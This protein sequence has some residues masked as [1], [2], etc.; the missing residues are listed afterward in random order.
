VHGDALAGAW[1]ALLDSLDRWLVLT[2]ADDAWE[3][4]YRDLRARADALTDQLAAMKVQSIMG[5]KTPLVRISG[6]MYRVGDTVSEDFTITSIEDRTVTL[7]ADGQ[8]FTLT[9]DLL[10]TGSKTGPARIGKGS[11]SGKK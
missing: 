4:A 2:T 6:E 8:K 5:G 1:A 3:H 11:P 7:K 10:Q 9:L